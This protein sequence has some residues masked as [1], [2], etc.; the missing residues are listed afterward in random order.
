[1]CIMMIF[2]PWTWSNELDIKLRENGEFIMQRRSYVKQF[3]IQ[4][5]RLVM[6]DEYSVKVVS[7]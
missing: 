2:I 3:K 6:D 7:E 4:A 1:M 5:V